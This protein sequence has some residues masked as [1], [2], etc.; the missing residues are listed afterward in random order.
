MRSDC[1]AHLMFLTFVTPDAR[2][3]CLLKVLHILNRYQ[4]L[5]VVNT[6]CDS[7]TICSFCRL[8][9]TCVLYGDILNNLY[10]PKSKS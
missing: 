3:G 2:E 1:L 10:N 9:K 8:A 4:H 5:Q 6:R 7:L